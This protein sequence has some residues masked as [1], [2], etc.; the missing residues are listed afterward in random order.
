MDSSGN[1]LLYVHTEALCMSRVGNSGRIPVLVPGDLEGP[2]KKSTQK[3]Q[4]TLS[5]R[6]EH[7][8]KCRSAGVLP[9]ERVASFNSTSLH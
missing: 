6:S 9:R 3:V 1:L 4:N 2:L 7:T 8:W 5:G